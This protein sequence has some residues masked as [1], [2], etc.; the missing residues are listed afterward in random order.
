L[1]LACLYFT[2]IK[3]PFFLALTFG[4]AFSFK[5]QAIFL[6]PFLL[7]LAVRGRLP[8]TYLLIIP[9]VYVVMM[10]PAAIFG[11][12]WSELLT[13][14]VA[15]GGQYESF[16]MNAPNLWYFL[17]GKFYRRKLGTLILIAGMG[18]GVIA[19]LIFAIF[20]ALKRIRLTPQ[21]LVLA[22][23]FCVTM[24]PFFL[25]KMH[26]RYF[27]SADLFSIALAFYD[28]TYWF[29][30]VLSQCISLSAYGPFIFN[31]KSLLPFV[32]FL[33]GALVFYLGLAYFDVHQQWRSFGAKMNT[34][35]GCMAPGIIA[36][37]VIVWLQELVL[38][39]IGAWVLL[40]SLLAIYYVTL[41][42]TSKLLE[43]APLLSVSDS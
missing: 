13:I 40:W 38:R 21:F 3:R 33:N 43:N 10:I 15:K 25:P 35:L 29:V 39:E 30:P 32:V 27:F 18:L 41:R 23:T 36:L 19:A 26:D 6:S 5:G 16:S 2:I 11:R 37:A 20:P 31:I 14:Y 4:L 17:G 28:P 22:A 8:W 1:L 7:M 12:P 9:V 42:Y 34:A 24:I